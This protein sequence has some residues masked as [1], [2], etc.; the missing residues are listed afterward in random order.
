LPRNPALL[1]RR[2][3]EDEV[4]TD[5]TQIEPDPGESNC[6]IEHA[7]EEARDPLEALAEEFLDQM[8]RGEQ[9][10]VHDFVARAAERAGELEE[11]LSALMFVEGF[12]READ[13]TADAAE[14][15]S[16]STNPVMERLGDFRIVRELGRGGMG[17]VYEAEQESLNRHVAIKVL[18]PGTSRSPQVIQRFLREARAAAQLHHTNIVPVFGVGERDGLHYY[19]MQFIRGLSL[20]KVLTEV[21]QLKIA[22]PAG[23]EQEQTA[24]H[25]GPAMATDSDEHYARSVARIGLEVAE[26]LEYAHQQGTLHRDIKPSNILLDVHGVA[27]VTDFGLAKAVEDEDLTRTGDLVGTIRYMAPERFGGRCDHRSDEYSLGLTLYELLALRPAF[28]GADRERLMYQVSRVEPPRLRSLNP[29]IPADLETI[30]HKAIE[31]EPGHRYQRAGALAD[32]LKCFLEDRPIAARRVGSTERLTRWARRN[33]GLATLGTALAGMLALVVAV[34][35]VSD[36]RLR[37]Q[38]EA[39]SAN[40]GRAL[41]AESNANSKLLDSNI[42]SARA[43]RRSSFA[44]QRFDSLDAIRAAALLDQPGNRVLELR[45][46]AIACLALPDLRPMRWWDTDPP[47]S[48][49]GVDFDPISGRVARGTPGGDVLIRSPDRQGD[50][51]RL[52]GMVLPVVMVRF[53]RD[54]HYLA[55]KHLGRGQVALVVWDARRAVK[56]LEIPGGIYSNAVDF[57]PDGRTLAAGRADGSIVVYDIDS[58]RELRRFGPGPAPSSIRFDSTG[59]RMLTVNTGTRDWVHVRATGDGTIKAS[60]PFSEYQYCAEWA[61]DGRWLACGDGSGT[62]RLLD[63]RDASRTLRTFRGHDGEVVALAFH[64]GGRLL[65]SAS[66]D[67]T[68]RLWDIE[69]SAQLVRCALPEA[70]PI[71]FSQ[72]GRF[73]GPG[74]DGGSL[75]IWEVADGAEYRSVLRAEDGDPKTW[76]IEFVPGTNVLVSAGQTGV[77]L[78]VQGDRTNAFLALPGT[79]GLALAPDGSYLITSGASGLLRWPITREAGSLRIGRPKPVAPLAGLPTGRVRIGREGRTLAVVLDGEAGRVVILD[80]QGGDTRV[81]VAG[82]RNLRHLDLSPDGRFLAT[83]TW[84]GRGVRV[85]DAHDGI[86]ARELEANTGA[87]VLFR[88]DG[89]LLVT[90]SGEEYAI[91]DLETWTRRVQIPRSQAAGVPGEASFNPAGDVLAIARKRN[92]VQLVDVESGRE[93]ASLEAPESKNITALGFSPDGRLLFVAL[94]IAGIRAWDLDAIRQG[95]QSV[96]LRWPAAMGA[97]PTLSSMFTPKVIEVETAPWTTALTRAQKLARSEH[98]K[99]AGEAFEEAVASGAEHVD[100]HYARALFR[101]ARGDQPAYSDACRQLLRMADAAQ[102][103]PHVANDIAWTCSLGPGAVADYSSVIH[104]AE[105]AAAGGPSHSRLNTLGAVLYRAGRFEEAARHLSQAVEIHGK[106]TELDALFLAMAH[107]KLG[108]GEEARRWL[109]RGTAVGPVAMHDSGAIGDET[110][111]LKLELEIFRSEA[112]A[113]IEPDRR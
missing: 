2:K 44:G 80:L 99:E 73:L 53:S 69:S 51:V 7:L 79:A 17:I 5:A 49:V 95:L 32:D 88:S 39:T 71:R 47:D 107:Q 25:P 15:G 43:G 56:L 62:I 60:L 52:A 34:I 98:W 4:K 22:T 94:G 97:G 31:K 23:A 87:N 61:P 66:W 6:R 64:P 20:E 35:A 100:A 74:L 96:G 19:A 40:L 37:R 78:S 14:K 45:N 81:N 26:A 93:L 67:G 112:S 28:E 30:V 42:A 105:M 63:A 103:V 65:A 27:W 109:R 21:R 16:P 57:H 86:L 83:G 55:V 113:M 38:H 18:A 89:K 3:W 12:K 70:R 41:A 29:A 77:R 110:W 33:P 84:Q 85:W 92:L 82:H 46:E 91:W 36:V 102:M 101:Q 108:H 90:A 13:A 111:N 75:S 76:C 68:M 48:F 24:I 1:T 106:G 50:E 72:D 58:K 59:E 11:L 9:P 104:L 10:S 54:G 8:R